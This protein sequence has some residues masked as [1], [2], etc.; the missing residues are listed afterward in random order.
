MNLNA[1]IESQVLEAYHAYWESYIKGDVKKLASLLDEQYSQI[2]SAESEV[3]LNKQDAVQF[4]E[5]T[6]SQVARKVDMRNRVIKIEPFDGLLLVNE[7]C[8]LYFKMEDTW[9]FYAKFRASSLMLQKE[10]EW[11][12]IHQ[13]SSMPDIR[14]E[15]GE[16]IAIEKITS[17]N[18]EL[19]DA[20]KRRTIELEHKNRELEIETSLERVRTVAMG[21]R[22]GDALMDICEVLFTELDKLGFIGLRNAMINIYDDA[23]ESFLNYDYSPV[24]GKTVTPFSYNIHPIIQR[25]VLQL[26]SSTDAFSEIVMTGNELAEFRAM[27]INNGEPDDPRFDNIT[28]ITYYFYS[29]DTGAIGLSSFSTITEENRKV[30]MRFR[31]VFDLAYRR[32]MDI[33]QA[34]AQAREAQI[35]AA[36]ERVRSRTMG[37]Q[38]S[39]ELKE[40][41]QIIY[42]QLSHLTINCNHAGFVVDYTPGGD[43]H[44]WIA[45]EQ[46]IPAKITHPYFESVWANQFNEAKATGANLFATYLN[47][48]EKNKFYHELLSYVPGLP[49]STKDFYLNCP[50]LA[51]STVLLDTVGLYIENF[52]AIPYTDEENNIL[53]RLGKVFQQTYTRFLDLKK[54]EA[55]AKE[56]QIE[57]ALEKVRS[58]TM[59]MQKSDELLDVAS[60]LFQQVKALGVLQW[61]CGFNIWEIGDEAFIYYPGTPDGIISQSPCKIPLTEHPVFK[62]FDES[63]RRGDELFIYEKEGDFQRSHYQYMLS[64]P[65]VGD[66]LQ[67]MLDAGFEFPAF[68]IDHVANF[69]Y[70]NLIFITYQHFPEMH[71]VFKRFAKVFEQTY[72]RFLDL[73]KAEGQAREAIKRASVDRVRAEIASMRTTGDL[74]RITPL[75]WNELNTLGVPFIRCG[76]FIM[77]EEHQQVHT[78]LSNPEGVAIAAFRQPFNTPGEIAEVVKSWRKKEMYTQHWDEA[79]F[80][81]FTRNLVQQD[82]ITSGEKYLT[83]NRPTDLCLHFLP[84]LQGMLYVGNTE[85]LSDDALQLVQN[86]ADAFSTAYARYEDFNNLEL[87]NVQI[88]KTLVD[89]KQTQAQLLQSEKMASLGELT[90]GIAH[91]IQNPLNFV[92]NFSEVNKE[93]LV[94]M[95]EEMGKGNFDDAIAIANDVIA[96]EEKINHHGKRADDIVKSMLQHSRSSS[97]AKEPTNI[98]SLADEYL[99]LAYHGFRAK[100][101]S[102]NAVMKTIFDESIGKINVIPQDMGRLMLNLINNAFYAVAEMKKL[103]DDNYEPTVSVSTR[104]LNH[105]I[106]IRVAD[107]G[108]GI[109]QK[110]L[111]KIFQPFFTT[112]P[113]GQGTGLGLSL[114][115]DIVK[116]HGGEIK[117]ETTEGEGSEFI[118]QLPIV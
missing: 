23:K 24:Q 43:W 49:E 83:E 42:Q 19:R 4:V 76:V 52:S 85:T 111:D 95:K 91:E 5:S 72:T 18:L 100:D 112:K 44:F 17:E 107:N 90:A 67:S 64:L 81:E 13:H 115:Y 27:R 15:D 70:G 32:Y 68:Q 11:K 78:Y 8:D 21:M 98:N 61:N 73:Q 58:R 7:Q 31:N 25:Q 1:A 37:M 117:A 26:R 29:T 9:S 108:K 53:L 86:L 22:N 38:K 96:N 102:F 118:I 36:L 46:D 45:D 39:D 55:Q 109:P 69:A 60:I 20:I 57:A 93:L 6:I 30:L 63:R 116:T 89:L 104:N 28:A 54:A 94:E 88:E 62:S 80:I 14:T 74:D 16:N 48:D 35:E 99:R 66:L 71:D 50:G 87:A 114:A 77:D 110:V 10:G 34:V 2:G 56:A 101:K 113:T 3:F 12:I 65:G 92:N 33:S 79:R 40:V 41:I 47:F 75:I 51:A 59:A 97:S 82:A 106:E 103:A 105:K 84:F